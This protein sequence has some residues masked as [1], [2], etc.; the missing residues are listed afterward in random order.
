MRST[1]SARSA[2]PANLAIHTCR[3]L[4][5][6]CLRRS[7]G[8]VS[9][10]VTKGY[11]AV[12]RAMERVVERSNERRVQSVRCEYENG[13]ICAGSAPSAA[14]RAYGKEKVYGSIP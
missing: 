9:K 5:P 3:P 6:G 14:G 7:Q 4:E 1:G 2:P 13:A 11:G 8:D 12:G 10:T